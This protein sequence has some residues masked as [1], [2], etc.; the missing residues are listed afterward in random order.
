M[1]KE[2]ANR[3]VIIFHCVASSILRKLN[4]AETPHDILRHRTSIEKSWLMM[5]KER[6]P[7]KYIVQQVR[8]EK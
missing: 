7:S 1:N 6:F 3:Q 5:S 8:V 4:D 2:P